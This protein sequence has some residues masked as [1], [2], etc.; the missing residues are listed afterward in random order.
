MVARKQR[1]KKKSII[2][3]YAEIIIVA[4]LLAMFVR[5]FF[6]QAFRIP[7]ESMEDTLLV[8]DFLFANKLIYGAKLPFVDVWLPSVRDPKPED[9]IIFK[10]PGDRK[11][12]YIKRC[13]AVAGQTVELKNS[14]L[15]IDGIRQSEEYSKYIRGTNIPRHFGPYTVPEN[16]VFMMGDN[17]DNSSDSRVW[18]ALDQDLI[19]GKAM[20][21]YFSWN[22]QSHMV[23]FSRIGDIIR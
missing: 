17:R 11:T 16:H 18:G 7:S 23:R 4:V 15:Y 10:Y 2:R 5:T 21:I 14:V 19:M 6:L 12:P 3:E 8:G 20:F 22:P 1:S 13:V 9:I